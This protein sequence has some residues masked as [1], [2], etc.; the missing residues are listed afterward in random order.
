MTEA[1]ERL[2]AALGERYGIE[3]E[4]GR[5]GMATVY[6]ARDVKHDRSVAVKVLHPELAATLGAE[7]FLR[8]IQ[9]AAQLSHPHILMLID[10]GEAAGFLYYVM[11]YVEGES[12]R[13]RLER[14]KQLPLDD[15]IQIARE[16]ASALSYA[17]SH[18][19]VHRDIGGAPVSMGQQ[20]QPRSGPRTSGLCDSWRLSAVPAVDGA[21]KLRCPTRSPSSPPRS[22][23][24]GN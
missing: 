1:L 15:A 22:R 16:V 13:D 7:R 12:V 18:N 3:R 14:E 11:P 21:E 2:T 6:L 4:L 24:Y 9:I 10:S 23:R 19:V 5:G 8:E 20:P 17:H